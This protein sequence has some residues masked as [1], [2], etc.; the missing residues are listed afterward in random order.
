MTEAITIRWATADDRDRILELAELDGR[1]APVGDTLLGL[2]GGRVWAAVGVD[3][4][5][6]VSDPFERAEDVVWL[7]QMRAEQERVMRGPGSLV[8]RLITVRQLGGSIA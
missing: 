4:G 2:V 5:G 6:A 1:P 7:L 8:G 3:D